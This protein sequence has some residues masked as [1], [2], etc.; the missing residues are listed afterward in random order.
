[1]LIPARRQEDDAEHSYLAFSSELL[2]STVV[3]DVRN[4]AFAQV[5]FL[6]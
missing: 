6:A 1:M 2:S 5:S 3:M 4:G